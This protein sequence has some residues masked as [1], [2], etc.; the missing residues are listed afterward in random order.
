MN[1]S[2][3]IPDLMVRRATVPVQQNVLT[4]WC[5]PDMDVQ[6][7]QSYKLCHSRCRGTCGGGAA[8][9]VLAE[10][11]SLMSLTPCVF[12]T[13]RGHLNPTV[14]AGQRCILQHVILSVS[15]Q[16]VEIASRHSSTLTP[17]SERYSNGSKES[18]KS[19]ESSSRH[20]DLRAC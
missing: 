6:V 4:F 11:P 13:Q 20:R 15:K 12:S 8:G 19:V 7:L 17:A 5:S 2:G 10:L 14:V 9:L 18:N 16:A 1:I 3:R